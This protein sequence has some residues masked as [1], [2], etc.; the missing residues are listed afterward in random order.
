MARVLRTALPILALAALLLVVACGDD[1]TPA[2]PGTPPTASTLTASATATN[3]VATA[4]TMCGDNDF[5]E[6]RLFRSSTPGIAQN[7]PASPVRISSSAGDTTFTDTGLDWNATYY[8]AVQTRDT[9]SLSSWSNE[10]QAVTPDSGS[11][12]G[13]LTC[14]QVQGQQ[15]ESPYLD[16]EVTVTGIVT[17]GGDEFYSSTLALGV[18]GDPAG[19]PWTGLALYGDEIESLARGDSVVLTGTVAEAFGLTELTFISDVQIISSGHT[20]PPATPI[21]TGDISNT[22]ANPEEYESVVCVVTDAMVTEV[23]TYGEF[24][25]D[26]GSGDCLGDDLGDY[27]WTPAVG[28]TVYSATGVVWYSYSEY[29]LEPRDDNDL[30]VSGGGPGD[31]LTCYQV[32]GQAASSPYADQIVSVTGIVVVGGDE[33]YASSGAYAVIMDASGGAWA[34][35]TLYGSDISGLVRGDSVTVTGEVQEYYEFTELAYP[36]AVTVHSTGHTLPAAELLDSGDVGEEQ[37]ES[38]LVGVTDVTVTEDDLGYGEW[39]VDDGSGEIRV[40]DMGDYTYTPNIGDSFSEIIG[41]CVY[42]YGD[43]KIEPRD[44]SDL[45]V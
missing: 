8:Y 22:D 19:G 6:Y 29:K 23:M 33:Y 20:P 26:D 9:E 39:A 44:D 30:D 31:V 38:V 5:S 12:G 32:Q 2:E 21:D 35:L 24:L 40:D 43:W 3:S 27:S 4:W 16:Q 28:D 7:P 41:V 25:M 17:V 37:W 10:V 36:T 45:T 18:I 34:G 1:E 13:V 15:A 42:L 14:Y 11:T